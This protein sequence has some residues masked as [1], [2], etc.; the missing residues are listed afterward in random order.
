[1]TELHADQPDQHPALVEPGKQV[2]RRLQQHMVERG[3]GDM[4]LQGMRVEIGIPYFNSYARCQPFLLAQLICQLLNHGDQQLFQVCNING[5]LLKCPFR[6]DRLSLTIRLDR[7]VVDTVRFLPDHNAVFPQHFLHHFHG[8]H[9]KGFYGIYSHGTE[10][11]VGLVADH[12]YF[13]D[14]QGRKERDHLLG[15]NLEPSIRLGLTGSNLRYR[16][17]DRQPERDGQAGFPD[18]L[19]PQL[20]GPFH[21]TKE[22]IHPAD[23]DVMLI[24]RCLFIHRGGLCNDIGD[25]FGILAVQLHVATDNNGIIA[26]VPRHLHG[27]GGMHPIFPCLIAAAGHHTP[28]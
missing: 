5:I 18:D 20:A 15:S 24:H 26:H 19:F 9:A 11:V 8:D 17:V 27:H 21:A 2:F 22:L 6:T 16:F 10:Q 25:R 1:M 7:G 3:V 28:V 12:R 14:R 23:V 4:L 13:P